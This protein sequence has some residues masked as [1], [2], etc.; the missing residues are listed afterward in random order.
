MNKHTIELEYEQIDAIVVSQL[1]EH[2]GYF[3]KPGG[4]PHYSFDEKEEAKQ[5]KKMI[6]SFKRILKYYGEP[7]EDC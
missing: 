4:L 3:L 6:K 2:L 1:K 5:V 7:L